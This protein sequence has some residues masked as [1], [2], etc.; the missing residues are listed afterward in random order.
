MRFPGSGASGRNCPAIAAG[1]NAEGIP[2]ARATQRGWRGPYVKNDK[3]LDDPWGEA[4]RYELREGGGYSLTSLGADRKS[5]GDGA[6]AELVL[7]DRD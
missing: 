3:A 2:T 7:G 1:L 4:L 6:A 5:G